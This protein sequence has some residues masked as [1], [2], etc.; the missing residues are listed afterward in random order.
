MTP[1]AA[2]KNLEFNRPQLRFIVSQPKEANSV[3]SRA[4]GKSSL[5]A[6]LMH[7]I[8]QQMP[9]SAWA[10]VGS[11]YMQILTRTLPSTIGSL[12]RIGYVKDV[13]YFIG[14]RPPPSWNWPTPYEPPVKFDHFISFYT[15]ASFHLV[16]QDK[17]GGSSRGLNIDGII[18]DESLLL[19]KERFD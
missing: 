7:L 11:T 9:R 4:T 8:A 15:G 17:G 10:L 13:H 16:S 2:K 18:A 3:W 12:E 14:R 19:D 1:N 5:I 6:W